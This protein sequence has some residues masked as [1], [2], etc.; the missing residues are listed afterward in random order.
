MEIQFGTDTVYIDSEDVWLLKE[1]NWYVKL[2]GT[3]KYLTARKGTKTLLFH[4]VIMAEPAGQLD[5]RDRNGLNNS[6]T[7]LRISTATQNQG[8]RSDSR[9]ASK[10]K[11]VR[12][13][14]KRW[15]AI[16]AQTTLGTYDTEEEA[17][18]AYNAYALV[19]F[20]EFAC[21]NPV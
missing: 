18:R 17:A 2:F 6:K 16:C 12:R 13:K 5:H 11:G 3:Q 7:N 8:N 14:R 4:R 21:L 20:G 9:G 10:F 19:Y 15:Q 1:F